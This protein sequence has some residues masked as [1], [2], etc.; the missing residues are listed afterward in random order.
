MLLRI[1]NPVYNNARTM[2]SRSSEQFGGA[3]HDDDNESIGSLYSGT[4]KTY[5]KTRRVS[6]NDTDSLGEK[7]RDTSAADLFVA[8][9]LSELSLDDI[10]SL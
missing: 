4:R 6:W 2:K 3:A 8:E 10:P 5:K 1:L 7:L 9:G